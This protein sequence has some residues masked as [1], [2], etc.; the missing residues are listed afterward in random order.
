[1]AGLNSSD[2]VEV[3]VIGTL[4]NQRTLNVFHYR[5]EADSGEP[6]YADAIT[7]FANGFDAGTQSP[8]LA[9]LACQCP[10]YT[11]VG[12][13]AQRVY[14]TRD[15]AYFSASGLPGT[16]AGECTQTNLAATIEKWSW[17]GGR[18]G[19][20]SMHLPAT[21]TEAQVAGSWVGPYLTLLASIAARLKLPY[22]PSEDP[23]CVAQP[24][25]YNRINKSASL[26]LQGATVKPTIRVMRRR[27]VGVG[28]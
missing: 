12:C 24:V 13:S 2:I 25:I 22:T 26:P 20:G 11:L 27:T 28:E 1:M 7:A 15:R 17:T 9:M 14:P 8:V 4:F 18:H 3:K 10:E 5:I 23:D 21:P 16:Y 19:I 6:V